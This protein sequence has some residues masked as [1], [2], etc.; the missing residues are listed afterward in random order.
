MSELG[1][2]IEYDRCRGPA[3]E[4]PGPYSAPGQ[5]SLS[6]KCH[7]AIFSTSPRRRPPLLLLSGQPRVPTP[8]LGLHSDLISHSRL[9]LGLVTVL[10]GCDSCFLKQ[11][12]RPLSY[13]QQ[14]D[15]KRGGNQ[16]EA[17]IETGKNEVWGI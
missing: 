2:C 14:R 5:L 4:S 16:R 15:W 6:V 8:E 7:A 1:D 17:L 3:W 13:C 9:L 10:V 12:W 11:R